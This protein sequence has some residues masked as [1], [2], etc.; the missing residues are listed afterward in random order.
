[1]SKKYI[2]TAFNVCYI[3]ILRSIYS[4]P[5]KWTHY[6][7]VSY[8]S[9]CT[10]LLNSIFRNEY[11]LLGSSVPCEIL[12]AGSYFFKRVYIYSNTVIFALLVLTQIRLIFTNCTIVKEMRMHSCIPVWTTM[13]LINYWYRHIP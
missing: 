8:F 5:I 13:L 12:L 10:L 4:F 11:A 3:K 6:T 7:I 2:C 1:M 9:A